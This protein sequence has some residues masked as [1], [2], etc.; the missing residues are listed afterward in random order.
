MYFSIIYLYKKQGEKY[1]TIK[2]KIK[3]FLSLIIG[4]IIIFPIF[5]LIFIEPI[6]ENVSGASSWTQTTETDF[7]AGTLNNTTIIGTGDDAELRIDI[8]AIQIWTLKTPPS[9]PQPRHQHTMAPIYG[10]NKVL[11][12]SGWSYTFGLFKDT[13]V[14]NLNNHTWTQKNPNNHPLGRASHAMASIYGDDKV[15][16]FGGTTYEHWAQFN[17]TWVYD[18]SDNNW[19]DKKPPSYPSK[20]RGHAMASIY[21]EKKVVLFGGSPS[22]ASPP[23]NET[24]VYNLTKN[25]WTL[26]YPPIK[27]NARVG[28]AMAPIYGTDKVLLFGGI[29]YSVNPRVVYNDTWIYDLSDNKWTKKSLPIKPN[30]RHSSAIAPIYGTDKVVIFGGTNDTSLNQE[31]IRNYVNDTWIYDLSENTW[32]QKK[33]TIKPSSRYMHA[34][35]SVYGRDIVVLFGGRQ[36]W[37][38]SGCYNDTWIYKPNLTP[39]NGTF[40]SAPYHIDGYPSFK[41]INWSCNTPTNTSIKLQL[42]AATNISVLRNMSFVGPD[43]TLGSFYATSPAKIWSGHKGDRWIQIIAYLNMSVLTDSPILKNITITYNCLPEIELISPIN[44]SILNINHPIFK[45]NFTDIDSVSQSAFQVLISNNQS[46]DEILFD[47]GEQPTSNQTWRFPNGTNYIILP[48]GN[49]YW[50]ARMKDNDGDWSEFSQPWTLMIDSKAPNSTLITPI[51]NSFYNSM[52]TLTGTAFDPP[53]GSGINKVEIVIKW[54]N[55]NYYWDG[56]NWVS[57]ES[58]LLA[59]GKNIWLYDSSSVPWLSSA[60]YNVQSRAIDNATNVEF[61]SIG[62]VFTYDNE[63]VVFSN[64]KPSSDYKSITEEVEVGITIS[65]TTSGVDAST[66]EYTVSEDKGEIWAPWVAVIGLEDEMSIKVTLTLTFPNG[67]GN[68]IKWRASDIAGNG[69]K[70]SQAY[71]VK[72]NT[73]LETHI[74]K[75]RLLT[76]KDGS[77]IP[78]NSVK[79]SWMLE[80]KDLLNVTYDVYF[81]TVNPPIELEETGLITTNLVVDDLSDGETYYWT[82][83][84]IANTDEGKIQGVC[85]SRIWSFTIE[86]GFVHVYGVNLKL[87]TQNLTVKQGEYIS[88]NI[89]VT[90]TG[91]SVDMI[92]LSLEKGI[93]DANVALEYLGTPV[94]LNT[95]ENITL[96]LEILVSELAKAQNYTISITAISNG[97]LSEKQNVSVTK[98]LNLKVV[99]KEIPEKKD[100]K[101][102]EETDLALWV[103]ILIIIIIILILILFLIIQRKK[104]AAKISV[105]KEEPLYK[106]PAYMP[107]PEATPSPVE[108]GAVPPPLTAEPE[109]PPPPTEPVAPPVV[110]TVPTEMEPAQPTTVPND[111][112]PPVPETESQV[113]IREDQSQAVQPQP[114]PVPKIKPPSGIEEE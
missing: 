86:V 61:P 77:I 63:N 12:F 43:G 37:P 29:D 94:R 54:L 7:N 73:W 27:P 64:P 8:L 95:S 71:T 112:E 81:D 15:V 89:T 2:I 21:G 44:G 35:A 41:L 84:P 103:I 105:V 42:R 82:V 25:T 31:L 1:I 69:P 106:S 52:N 51:N 91:N 59:S 24:W 108:E 57:S 18:L 56:S 28:H 104:K 20:R 83:I 10:T 99:R 60:Q 16:I 114:K 66:I 53:D 32:T 88:T 93:L 92:N 33:V 23:D 102:K 78:S 34:M 87:E 97:A 101:R 39:I 67:T 98:L 19:T 36:N 22:D 50:K 9:P 17:D 13:W 40:I 30:G 11:L 79:L 85:E 96:K 62:N 113:P 80:N 48:E 3:L 14:Y 107:L 90:N 4:I 5:Q 6:I 45:W 47:S 65:D 109:T 38:S 49:W 55:N 76:P 110:P 58:W 70:E 111:E 46:F 100:Q 74:P 75:V 72:V 68:R 26:F